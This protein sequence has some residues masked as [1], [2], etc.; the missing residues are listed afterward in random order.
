MIPPHAL[1]RKLPRKHFNSARSFHPGRS[2]DGDDFDQRNPCLRQPT[3]ILRLKGRTGDEHEA[4]RRASS[5]AR[6]QGQ[7]GS[8]G[9]DEH[10]SDASPNP[11]LRGCCEEWSSRVTPTSYAWPRCSPQRPMQ[12]GGV[13]TIAAF[14]PTGAHGAQVP[15]PV[16]GACA[17]SDVFFLP[18][19]W[20]MTHTDARIAATEKRC[21]RVDDVRGDRGL[22]VRGRDPRRLRGGGPEGSA[23]GRDHGRG[24]QHPDDFRRR[25]RPHGAGD[26]AT[27]SVRDRTVPRA[28]PVRSATQQRAQHLSR[29]RARPRAS[30]SAMCA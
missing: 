8:G 27:G 26:R 30:S 12:F 13:P 1:P 4:L 9:R 22:P 29:S 16:V 3:R 10:R 19:S 7:R 5:G 6:H 11:G 20:S 17:R 2:L 14:P 18:T 21:P 28:G 23:A 15:Q 25:H 24:H